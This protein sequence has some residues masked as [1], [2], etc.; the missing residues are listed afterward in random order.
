MV[1]KSS[2]VNSQRGVED[3]SS[4]T[5]GLHVVDGKD[6]SSTYDALLALCDNTK[7]MELPQ[8]KQKCIEIFNTTHYI[9]RYGGKTLVCERT[10][11]EKGSVVYEFWSTEELKKYYASLNFETQSGQRI[12]MLNCFDI[13]FKHTKRNTCQGVIFDPLGEF[14]KSSTGFLNLWTGFA[15]DPVLGEHHIERILWHLLHIIC[16]GNEEHFFYLLAW[17]AQL[18]QK[19][20]EKTG[21]CIVLK[22]DARGTG[23]S[24]VAKLI[25]GILGEHCITVQDTKQFLGQYNMHLINKMFVTVEEAFWSGSEENAGKLKTL[26]TE[27]SIVIEGKYKDSLVFSSY[28]RYMLITNN[29]WAVPVTWNERR[30]MVYEVS[31]KM[32]GNKEYFKNLYRDINDP[33]VIGQF[34]NFLQN[35]DISHYDL[36]KAPYTE[37]IQK[38]VMESLRIHEQWLQDWLEIGELVDG[39]Q[40]YCLE[41]TQCIPKKSLYND[42]LDYCT[43]R[44]AKSSA[45]LSNSKLSD[46]LIQ[47]LKLKDGGR[48]TINGKRTLHL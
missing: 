18:I 11:N 27:S 2:S 34:L 17:L 9:V 20:K 13:W 21:I 38:Q 29:D 23:K 6:Y 22:S 10:R 14:G 28:H 44:G 3:D 43:R 5:T 1:I 37:G 40:T 31:E 24:T 7:G 33:Q 32:V 8:I 42:Y 12:K 25:E 4:S 19:P 47:V 26:V 46:Y 41:N 39:N 16:N 36:R 15:V 30:F 48:P 35:F 45:R